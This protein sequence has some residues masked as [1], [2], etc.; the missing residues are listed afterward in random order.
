ML[1]FFLLYTIYSIFCGVIYELMCLPYCL[2]CLYRLFRLPCLF[3][4]GASFSSF[5]LIVYRIFYQPKKTKNMDRISVSGEGTKAFYDF[6]L[7][8]ALPRLYSGGVYPPPGACLISRTKEK[9]TAQ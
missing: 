4:T 5:R 9:N 2:Y 3:T 6:W 8:E 1:L 7:L